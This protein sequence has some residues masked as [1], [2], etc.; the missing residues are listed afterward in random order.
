M[1]PLSNSEY[2]SFVAA[3][4]GER[5]ERFLF[6]RASKKLRTG[7]GVRPEGVFLDR[8]LPRT[9]REWR[10]NQQWSISFADRH[11]AACDAAWRAFWR[12]MTDV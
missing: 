9:M 3:V 6:D 2:E 7:T 8:E 5:Y 11:Q 4:R 1:K 12:V 10:Q